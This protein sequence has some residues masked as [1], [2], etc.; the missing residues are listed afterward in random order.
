MSRLSAGPVLVPVIP[1]PFEVCTV[2]AGQGSERPPVQGKKWPSPCRVCRVTSASPCPMRNAGSLWAD[3]MHVSGLDCFNCSA[4][5]ESRPSGQP[6][7]AAPDDSKSGQPA[8]L[9]KSVAWADSFVLSHGR[10]RD[11]GSGG[12]FSSSID[13]S[14]R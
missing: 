9:V 13:V 14:L 11:G 2:W 4:V 3:E 7:W 1:Q 8:A 10:G 6:R 5:Q 12:P